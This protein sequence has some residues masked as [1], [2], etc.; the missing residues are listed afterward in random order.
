MRGA[1]HLSF[2]AASSRFFFASAAWRQACDGERMRASTAAAAAERHAAH[3]ALQETMARGAPRRKQESAQARW[4]RP[5]D[6]EAHALAERHPYVGWSR[7]SPL[8]Y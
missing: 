1:A 6:A 8:P 2:A 7:H 5:T 3:V 4:K